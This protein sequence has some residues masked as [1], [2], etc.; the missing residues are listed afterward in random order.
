MAGVRRHG[1]QSLN[2]PVAPERRHACG[3]VVL[4]DSDDDCEFI[5]RQTWI[6]FGEFDFS[7]RHGLHLRLA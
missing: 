2:P 3:H 5:V 7:Q 4:D 6:C 1:E